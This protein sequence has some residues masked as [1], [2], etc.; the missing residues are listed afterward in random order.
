MALG[1]GGRPDPDA[2]AAFMRAAARRY[3]GG[4]PA[5]PR[6]RYWQIWNEPNITPYLSPQ[7]RGKRPV[8][9]AYY[10]AML[11]GAARAIHE[12]RADN[13][14]V[15]GALSPFTAD[16]GSVES[17]GPL[18]FMR[19]LLCLSSGPKPRPTCS[20]RVEFD[21]WAH[22]PYTSGGPTHHAAHADDVSLGDLGEMRALL[23][24]ARRAGRIRAP[25]GIGFWVTE[26]SWDS[27][28]ADPRG[29]PEVL[30]ARWVS[31]ALHEMWKAGVTVATWFKLRD[32]PFPSTPY[33]S[34]LYARGATP[35]QDRPR[36][37]LAAFRFPFVA[38][39]GSKGVLVWGRTPGGKQAR[40]VIEQ[41]SIGGG[42]RR[43]ALLRT[44]RYGIVQGRLALPRSTKRDVIRAR[45]AGGNIAA[46]PFSLQPQPDRV[47]NPFGT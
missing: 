18:R 12:V 7:F 17:V 26:F 27:K 28:S 32:E 36:P 11:N 25:R 34:G 23:D 9:A 33:Q 22:H 2:L 29:V 24:A 40:I 47:Y 37:S 8:A 43:V 6:I 5:H 21:V 4:D 15:A 1:V 42:W 10:R 41:K 16:Y 44:D 38:Y 19:D 14:V 3:S 31:E 45:V 20:T 35:A 30:R 39:L 46:L 13:V